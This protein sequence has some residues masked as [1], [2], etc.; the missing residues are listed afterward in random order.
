MFMEQMTQYA[1]LIERDAIATRALRQAERYFSLF[2][3]SETDICKKTKIMG[4][5][6]DAQIEA[7][8][9]N[10]QLNDFIQKTGIGGR[11]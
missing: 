4:V 11:N 10:T 8:Y 5:L 7:L 1:I 2:Y 6:V 3:D 9:T